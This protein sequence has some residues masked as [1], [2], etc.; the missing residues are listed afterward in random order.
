MKEAASLYIQDQ[1]SSA[2]PLHSPHGGTWALHSCFAPEEGL[3]PPLCTQTIFHEASLQWAESS[4]RLG[5]LSALTS[6]QRGGWRGQAWVP[7]CPFQ[8][9]S[10]WEGDRPA[11]LK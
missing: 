1:I 4:A 8:L 11:S 2:P 5:Q 3:G 10:E 7:K 9:Q 6:P